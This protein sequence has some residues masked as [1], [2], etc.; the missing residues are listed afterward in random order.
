MTHESAT[1]NTI[2]PLYD[3]QRMSALQVTYFHRKPRQNANFSI[4][5]V[6]EDVRRELKGLIDARVCVAPYLSN[7]I[8]RRLSI[9]LH[10]RRHQGEINHVTGDTNFT[11]ILLPGKRTILTNHDCGYMHHN[12]GWRRWLLQKFWLELPVRRV[13]AVTTVSSQIKKEI[14]RYTGC[15]ADKVWVI[16]N[17][18]SPAFKPVL[19][20]F[21]SARPRIL[22][23][24]TAPNKNLSR[25]IDAVTGLE[26]TLVIVGCLDAKLRRRLR[27]KRIE[28]ENYI[29][30]PL[31]ALVHQYELC[32]LLV[33]AS[34]YE[35]FGVPI[36]EA[37]AVGRPIVTSDRA[38]MSEIAGKGASLVNPTDPQD[39]QAAIVK[40]CR[41]A[42]YRQQ[43]VDAGSDNVK[44]YAPRR[45]AEQYYQLYKHVNSRGRERVSTHGTATPA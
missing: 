28:F 33:F 44:R 26:C 39:I 24:G 9:V 30:L 32:D 7:G 27:D 1:A 16:P 5:G 22:Q 13:A 12:R 8:L 40:I 14:V 23:V 35:G 18:P 17:A 38:P 15:P 21:Y 11:A 41:D 19:K 43:L 45:I 42:D 34:L 25:L 29:D 10:A 37:Q 6:F 4:E 31:P 2:P 20:A 3:S 36:L